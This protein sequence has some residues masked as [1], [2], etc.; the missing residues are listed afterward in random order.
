METTGL[1]KQRAEQGDP[2]AL[3]RLGYRLAFGRSRIRPTQWAAVFPLWEQAARAGYG[4][5]MFYLGA[6]HEHGYGTAKDLTQATHWYKMAAQKGH[7]VAMFN[8][9]L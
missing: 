2:D 7:V 3:F 6:C 4:R 5:A 9:A 8:L 1:L